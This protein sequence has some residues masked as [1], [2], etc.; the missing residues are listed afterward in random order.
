MVLKFNCD[1]T[2]ICDDAVLI[3]L[4]SRELVSDTLFV[5]H[6]LVSGDLSI[7]VN[8]HGLDWFDAIL[9][10]ILIHVNPIK[11]K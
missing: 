3:Q 2:Y 7:F 10:A 4:V 8:F 6:V 5:S 9:S 1:V 11:S